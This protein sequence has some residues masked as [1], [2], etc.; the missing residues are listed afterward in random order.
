[1]W[2]W[3][4]HVSGSV[5]SGSRAAFLSVVTPLART[6]AMSVFPVAP[7]LEM[8]MLGERPGE[9]EF[10]KDQ[11]AAIK[12]LQDFATGAADQIAHLLLDAGE[13]G[14]GDAVHLVEPVQVAVAQR[15]ADD[16]HALAI[17]LRQRL[18]HI[19]RPHVVEDAL[20][21]AADVPVLVHRRPRVVAE[22]RV[23]RC[24][25]HVPALRQLRRVVQVLQAVHPGTGELIKVRSL[26]SGEG[27]RW[28][29]EMA[30]KNFKA[31]DKDG[32]GVLT[33][34][35]FVGKKK[36]DAAEKAEQIFKLIDTDADGKLTLK[37][38]VN[39]SPEAKFKPMDKDG[40]GKL[41]WEEFK[42]TRKP[43]ELDQAE[44]NFKR[45]DTDGDKCLCLDEFKA[46]QKP[47]AK[48]AKK[49]A[50]KKFQPKQVESAGKE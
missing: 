8:C 28:L 7:T 34:G 22:A 15:V 1:M 26:L 27:I 35:E 19:Y 9:A 31:Q 18:Q 11:Q 25:R 30:E 21:G 37:E 43:E 6:H 47:P 42:G 5:I 23:V 33:C 16:A 36:P 49:A 2:I 40:D 46:G 20:H 45:M 4:N 17:H 50:G 29:F 48:P 39:R 10:H 38:F 14:I 32:D 24:Q 13:V 12:K 44:Q 41:T 3:L